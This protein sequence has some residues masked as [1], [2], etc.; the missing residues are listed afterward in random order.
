MR[1]EDSLELSISNLANRGLRSWLTV[2]GIAIG[3][4]AVVAILSIGAGMEANLSSRLSGFGTDVVTITPGY[5]GSSQ[6]GFRFGGGGGAV[7]SGNLTEV[8]EA[9]LRPVLG[10]KYVEGR[11]SG[12]RDVIY[13]DERITASVTGVNPQIWRYTTTAELA[14][15]RY[16]SPG[17]T[18]VVVVGDRIATKTFKRPL[19]LGRQLRIGNQTFTVVG[20]L[21]P[22]TTSSD[23]NAIFTPRDAARKVMTEVGPR[24][25]TSIVVKTTPD[26]NVSRVSEELEKR[27]LITHHV[28]SDKK[29]FT[30]NSMQATAAR[31]A[32]ILSSTTLF[33]GAIAAVSLLVGG[34]GIANT[35]Y[36]SVLERT[37][38]IGILKALGTTNREVMRLY[39]IE[40]GLMGLVG[41]IL[42][43]SLGAM[44]SSLIPR[45]G[46]SVM[47]LGGGSMTTVIT[48]K[49][50]VLSLIFS[51]IVGMFSGV[52]PAKM[53]ADLQPVE[54]LRYE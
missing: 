24:E 2:L 31:L 14:A 53:A 19:T 28:T 26:A 47:G 44:I 54:A 50:I 39:L 7:K 27:L 30:V 29:D 51:M 3:I 10:V 40:S 41:G 4:A 9:F 45:L 52:Y 36:M 32:D 23:D 5:S 6:Q 12:R 33:L 37:R 18:F 48:P 35:M 49:L 1:L 11:V 25:F 42:G 34:I 21:K 22:S 43:A 15:G 16:L 17:D 38:Q 20:I 8:D 13:V 46:V